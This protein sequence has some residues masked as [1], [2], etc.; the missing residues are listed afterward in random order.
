[1][2]WSL[3]DEVVLDQANNSAALFQRIKQLNPAAP[4]TAVTGN[5]TH[6]AGMAVNLPGALRRF[7]LLP[8]SV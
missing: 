7:G 8:P 3:A 1:M 5:W 6:S 4:V 2:F